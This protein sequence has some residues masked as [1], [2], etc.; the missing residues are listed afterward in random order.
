MQ[1]LEINLCLNIVFCD[2]VAVSVL[3]IA[4]KS[5][6]TQRG[7]SE[8]YENALRNNNS[9]PEMRVLRQARSWKT[10]IDVT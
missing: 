1:F 2:K 8:F 4:C 3:S 7:G 9:I 6:S 5:K 10:V